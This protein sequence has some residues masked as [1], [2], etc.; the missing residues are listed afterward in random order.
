MK[1]KLF[2]KNII[3]EARDFAIKKHNGQKYG[4]HDYV[5]HLDRVFKIAEEFNLDDRYK[6]AAYLHDVIEDTKTTKEEI[7]EKFGVWMSE[8]VD[9]VSGFGEN[10]KERKANMIAKI[11]NFEDSINLKMIDRLANMRECYLNKN[12]KLLNMY[13]K[14]IDD[15]E[16]IFSVGN[17]ELFNAIKMFKNSVVE[18]KKL[19]F[20]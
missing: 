20:K 17:K 8:V 19:K 7:K 9:A 15:Y 3:E 2:M 13:I 14:E 10:R 4:E 12:E 16:E 6:V 11:K 18:N 1:V 5:Y